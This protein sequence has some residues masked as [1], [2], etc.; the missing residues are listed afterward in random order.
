MKAKDIFLEFKRKMPG[1]PAAKSEQIPRG[2]EWRRQGD[3]MLVWR[4]RGWEGVGKTKM[5]KWGSQSVKECL[6][7]KD[8][9]ENGKFSYAVAFFREPSGTPQASYSKA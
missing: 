8:M 5:L 2:R 9:E 4:S 3:T 7:R 1:R 6:L